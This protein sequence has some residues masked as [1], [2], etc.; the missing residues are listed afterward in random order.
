MS[1]QRNLRRLVEYRHLPP[2]PDAESGERG[3]PFR[4]T[5]IT[6]RHFG[7]F[8]LAKSVWTAAYSRANH[9]IRPMRVG[10]RFVF[11]RKTPSVGRRRLADELLR[12]AGRMVQTQ[13][14]DRLVLA[15]GWQPAPPHLTSR[16]RCGFPRQKGYNSRAKAVDRAIN[17]SE[18]ARSAWCRLQR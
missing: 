2:K 4:W 5:V 15:A 16:Q 11:A 3:K 9:P 1:I 7:M 14:R 17:L 18:P 10:Q 8:V 12:I 6:P 13:P